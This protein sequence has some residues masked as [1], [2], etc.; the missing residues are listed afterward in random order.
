MTKIKQVV[1]KP[2]PCEFDQFLG[3]LDLESHPDW[4]EAWATQNTKLFE[5]VLWEMGADL[6]YGY[7]FT[8]CLHRARISQ[9]VEF[10]MRVTFKERNDDYWIKNY[11][12]V[13]DIAR[14]DKSSIVRCGMRLSLNEDSCINDLMVDRLSEE[15][16]LH[17]K[18][19]HSNAVVEKNGKGKK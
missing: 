2:D 13:E 19:E 15:Q 7:E 11:M 14:C 9:K 17:S 18:S 5:K 3:Q 10:G 16:R 1:R 6:D 4:K 8:T 12:Q